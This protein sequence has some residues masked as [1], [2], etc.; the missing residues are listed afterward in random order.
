MS[1]FGLERE[2][3]RSEHA[4]ESDCKYPSSSGRP[5]DTLFLFDDKHLGATAGAHAVQGAPHCHTWCNCAFYYVFTIWSNLERSKLAKINSLDHEDTEEVDGEKDEKTGWRAFF[6]SRKNCQALESESKTKGQVKL[7]PVSILFSP[8][9]SPPPPPSLSLCLSLSLSFFFSPHSVE[10]HDS[11]TYESTSYHGMKYHFRSID[12]W[13]QGICKRCV[14]KLIM[15]IWWIYRSSA[16]TCSDMC[17]VVMGS[18]G[19]RLWKTIIALIFKKK[20]QKLEARSFSTKHQQCIVFS[21]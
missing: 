4:G 5:S 21:S 20:K 15:Q 12:T 7:N 8:L 18:G 9:P 1:R 11:Y 2:R 14:H 17:I 6:Q 16:C 3:R 19:P 13:L 10:L